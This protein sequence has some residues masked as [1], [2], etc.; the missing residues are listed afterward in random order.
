M[1]FPRQI[2]AGNTVMITRRT[3]LRTFLLRPDPQVRQIYLYCLAVLAARYDIDV[4]VP[5]LMSTHEHLMVTDRS[6]Q[7]PAFVRDLHR[8]VAQCI[9]AL[10]D[11]EGSVWDQRR[12]S[13]VQLVTPEAIVETA[14]YM[15]ANPV[16]AGLVLN[17]AEWPGVTI[18]PSQLGR[19]RWTIARP[20]VYFSRT[21]ALW[22]DTATLEIA[23]PASLDNTPDAVRTAIA[24]QVA[25]AEAFA[26]A[27]MRARGLKFLGREYVLLCSPFERAKGS[28]QAP[29]H[30]P[31]FA[32]GRGQK[33][34]YRNAIG[35][36]RAFRLAY[37]EALGSWRNGARDVGF[38]PGTWLMVRLHR[39]R[40]EAVPDPLARAS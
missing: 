33:D 38:P 31:T 20:N 16:A 9:K 30:N 26:A 5:M 32:V 6:G 19:A 39:A 14:A 2:L 15:I 34:A 24:E 4:H 36:V 1:A 29:G 11:W 10:R 18:A 22:P 8:T 23:M 21:N 13:I 27:D 37:R 7:L 35:N 25:E 40:V 3:V 28:E 17:A 12:T